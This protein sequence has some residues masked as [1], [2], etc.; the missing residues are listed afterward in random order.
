METAER[1]QPDPESA[2]SLEE[3]KHAADIKLR[4]AELELKRRESRFWRNPTALAV[5]ALAGT[6]GA[7]II[8]HHFELSLEE[9]RSQKEL[10]LEHSRAQSS[11]ILEAIKTGDPAKASSNLKFLIEVGLLDDPG[12]K[13]TI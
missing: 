3:R 11:L 5:L 12:Q 7:A 2:A 1:Q 6:I 4:S 8:Q 10:I 13:L 9:R